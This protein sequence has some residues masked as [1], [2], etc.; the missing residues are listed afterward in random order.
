[1]SKLAGAPTAS[2]ELCANRP[3][4]Y[5]AR[6][7]VAVLPQVANGLQQQQGVP[8]AFGSPN[9]DYDAGAKEPMSRKG[10]GMLRFK[11]AGRDVQS[12]AWLGDKVARQ[13]SVSSIA[14]TAEQGPRSVGNDRMSQASLGKPAS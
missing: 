13:R 3:A 4:R 2:P 6:A 1:M 9:T 14:R 5:R 12:G 10:S 11:A 7:N 8:S